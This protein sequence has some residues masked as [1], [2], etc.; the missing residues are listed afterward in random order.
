MVVIALGNLSR[1]YYNSRPVTAEIGSSPPPNPKLDRWNKMDRWHGAE[2]PLVNKLYNINP[3]GRKEF[4]P[5]FFLFLNSHLF[6]TV[7]SIKV[8]LSF[9]GRTNQMPKMFNLHITSLLNNA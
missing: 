7:L 1:V 6:K 8:L 5:S 4:F 2:C 3:H 9:N